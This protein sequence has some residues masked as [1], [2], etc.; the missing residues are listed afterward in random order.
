M[1]K[2]KNEYSEELSKRAENFATDMIIR[3]LNKI[4]VSRY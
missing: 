3:S 4:K 2:L 1:A